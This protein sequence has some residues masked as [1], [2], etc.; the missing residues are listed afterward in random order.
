MARCYDTE[1]G[2]MFCF[3][4]DVEFTH[5]Q[6][7]GKIYEQQLVLETLVPTINRIEGKKVILDIGAHIGSHSILYSKYIPDCE[8]YSF[9]P[10]KELY[11]LLVRNVEING[12]TNVK[13]YNTCVGHA[14]QTCSMSKI[15]RDGYDLVVDYNTTKSFNYGGIQLGL[16]GE[17]VEM[18][19]VDS[20]KLHACNYMKIDVEGAEPLVIMG[21]LETIRK[22]KPIIFFEHTDKIVNAEMKASLSI[23]FDVPSSI[24][25]LI[26][27]GYTIT[28]V[29]QN[30]KLARPVHIQY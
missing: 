21:A 14:M 7:N 16:G 28:D 2:Q 25:L 1:H 11:N 22:Y 9:E 6:K 8:I 12:L 10:Q 4:N 26:R 30:N 13:M 29:D 27:E 3:E 19:T 18:L 24:E 15:L 23:D 20:L 5:A 17:P